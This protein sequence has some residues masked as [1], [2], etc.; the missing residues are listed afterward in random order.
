MNL[1]QLI[2]QYCAHRNDGT[3]SQCAH[4]GGPLTAKAEKVIEAVAQVGLPLAA[5]ALPEV[6]KNLPGVLSK[7][8]GAIQW[9]AVVAALGI[10]G[11]LAAAALHSCSAS[12]FPGHLG[13]PAAGV[14]GLPAALRSAS[15]CTPF[16][17]ARKIDKCV[18]TAND[19]L[20][21]GGITGGQDLSYYR[22]ADSADQIAAAVARWRAD[23]GTI[24]SDAPRFISI[25]PSANVRFADA[26]NG[27]QVETGT[28]TG[29][30]AAQT[31]LLRA[32]MSY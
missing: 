17:A 31:F 15:V 9:Q 28:F 29:R 11:V 18:V 10:V 13:A 1:S 22:Q 21:A 12:P 19:P 16:D 32:G 5:K 14:D 24:V 6:G 3:K 23:G 25:G 20:L 2:C 27:V 7:I 26:G 4:C 8:G 30:T